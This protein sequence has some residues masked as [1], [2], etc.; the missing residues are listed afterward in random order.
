M[1]NKLQTL[2]SKLEKIDGV[3]VEQED[4]VSICV[5]VGQTYTVFMEDGQLVYQ[6]EYNGIRN[7]VEVEPFIEFMEKEVEMA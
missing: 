6:E 2:K 3:D 5:S 1:H 4:A 7:P